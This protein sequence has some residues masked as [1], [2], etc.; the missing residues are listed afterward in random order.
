MATHNYYIGG[1]T[2]GIKS[3]PPVNTE[4]EITLTCQSC[5]DTHGETVERNCR[6][7]KFECER[8]GATN[9]VSMF[10]S[11]NG[12]AFRYQSVEEVVGDD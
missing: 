10:R 12:M 1:K 8:C 3:I 9:N 5:G 6:F 2:K 7:C 4:L 11:G